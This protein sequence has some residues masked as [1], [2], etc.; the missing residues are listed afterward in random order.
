MRFSLDID[1]YFSMDKCAV[2]NTA[3]IKIIRLLFIH[4]IPKLSGED[5]YKYLGVLEGIYII[6]S[7]VKEVYGRSMWQE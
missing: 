3:K 6:H 1:M 5:S 7:A 2:I 4:N